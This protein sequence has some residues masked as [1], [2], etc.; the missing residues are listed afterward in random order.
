MLG[1]LT[2][3][4]VAVLAIC[5]ISGLLAMYRG[6]TREMLSILSWA[7]AAVATLYVVLYRKD[8]AEQLAD[9]ALR[10]TSLAQIVIGCIVFVFT[11]IIVHLI[12]MRLSDRVLDSRVGMIDRILGFVFGLA[13]GFLIVVIAYMFFD[14]IQEEQGQP[15][16]VRE[17]RSIEI[18]RDSGNS[19]RSLLSSFMPEDIDNLRGGDRG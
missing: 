1:P 4:D 7:L 6:L 17:A 18:I 8:L 11:L 12:T 10:S 13:R 5:V 19:L 2:Y 16:W 3:L 14:F 15:Q 9:Q